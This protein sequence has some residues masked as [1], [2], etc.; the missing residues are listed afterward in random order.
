MHDFLSSELSSF[1]KWLFY[2]FLVKLEEVREL[3]I[4]M[5]R[6]MNAERENKELKEML[7][8]FKEKPIPPMPVG[9]GPNPQDMSQDEAH[10]IRYT[11]FLRKKLEQMVKE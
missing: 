3:E 5:E 9:I 8:E 7:E 6:V 11:E 1:V 4:K 10:A 2:I